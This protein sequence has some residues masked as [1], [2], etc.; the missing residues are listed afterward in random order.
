MQFF[1]AF[2]GR[3]NKLLSKYHSSSHLS[4]NGSYFCGNM[5][6]NSKKNCKSGYRSEESFDKCSSCGKFYPHNSCA[7]RHV[8]CLN[9][10][11][12]G[13]LKLIC[14][15]IVHFATSVSNDQQ[16]LSRFQKLISICRI[17][18]TPLLVHSTSLLLTQAV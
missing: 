11:K 3:R 6:N 17:G 18:C 7:L 1:V 14:K 9:C 13:H 12:T 4:N 2:L 10:G 5:K 8:K 15:A 16:S